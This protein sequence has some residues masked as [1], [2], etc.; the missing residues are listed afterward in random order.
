M[1]IGGGQPRVISVL[2]S[3]EQINYLGPLGISTGEG[4]SIQTENMCLAYE[5]DD[6]II[7][8]RKDRIVSLQKQYIKGFNSLSTTITFP[9]RKECSHLA[10]YWIEYK[11]IYYKL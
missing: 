11:K 8:L 10:K 2:G 6:S 9:L 4:S 5:N 7:I 1:A 3:E